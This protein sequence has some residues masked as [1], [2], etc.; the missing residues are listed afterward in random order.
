MVFRC[1]E[2]RFYEVWCS[3]VSNDLQI[4]AEAAEVFENSDKIIKLLLIFTP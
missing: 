4:L 2:A 3:S 1:W